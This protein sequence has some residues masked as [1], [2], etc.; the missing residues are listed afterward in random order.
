VLLVADW[1]AATP[2]RGAVEEV[3][4]AAAVEDDDV[5]TAVVMLVV[6]DRVVV[7]VA[8]DRVVVLVARERVVVLVVGD[9]PA[10][11]VVVVVVA[12]ATTRLAPAAE[13]AADVLDE[14]MVAPEPPQ[15]ASASPTPTPSR[16][17][18]AAFGFLIE[19][20]QRLSLAIDAGN[21]Y[22][23]HRRERERWPVEQR[24]RVGAALPNAI[25]CL[26]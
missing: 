21:G 15:A 18:A 14:V 3:E 20:L 19:R 10:V 23:P 2:P 1:L 24:R 5:D 16:R 13:F 8:R 6:R 4:V 7:L 25:A 26:T 11:A 17:P 9:R 22:R 12:A